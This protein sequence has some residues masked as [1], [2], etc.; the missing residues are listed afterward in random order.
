MWMRDGGTPQS[1]SAWV[2]DSMNGLGPQ[3]NA[4]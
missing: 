2:T 4:V 1:R 3:T